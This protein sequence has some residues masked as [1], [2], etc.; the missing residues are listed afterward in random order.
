MRLLCFFKTD[1]CSTYLFDD[2]LGGLVDWVDV[3]CVVFKERSKALGYIESNI[4]QST[5]LVPTDEVAA[6][7][8]PENVNQLRVSVVQCHNV[9]SHRKGNS[10]YK[11]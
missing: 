10:E 6:R 2:I 7:R 1:T 9:K 5:K 8:A 3:C 4:S 11:G